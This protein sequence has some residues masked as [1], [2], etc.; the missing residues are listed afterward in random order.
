MKPF[1]FL[2]GS[3]GFIGKH[4]AEDKVF[5]QYNLLTPVRNELELADTHAVN[6]YFNS[7]NDSIDYIIHA[8]NVGGTRNSQ[9]LEAH[10]LH[11]NVMGFRNVFQHHE[12]VKRFIQLGSGA[13]YG[14]P[15]YKP[16]IQEEDIGKHLPKDAYGLS[17]F[18]CGN[19][20]ENS[21]KGQVVNLRIF[22]I[23]GPYEDYTMRFISNAIVRS[24]LGLP[25]VVNQNAEF[26]Y[27]Y[28]KDFM[29]ILNYFIENPAP[30][31]SYN[32]TSGHPLTLLHIAQ[33]VKKLTKNKYDLVVKNA[34]VNQSYTGCNK[35]LLDFLPRNFLFTN[36]TEAIEELIAW[37]K[38]NITTIS[39]EK[40]VLEKM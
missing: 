19:V 35:R 32:V 30:Y 6:Q 38:D 26:D 2:T 37:Y 23:F 1:I 18:L 16:K 39:I 21:C 25:V 15:F 27:L 34:V 11:E 20:V 22:G 36:I 9:L 40:M 7:Y 17:K 10:C 5:K 12:K 33:I 8:A 29:K 4:I 28:V 24:L 13:E 3:R 31:A 14:K